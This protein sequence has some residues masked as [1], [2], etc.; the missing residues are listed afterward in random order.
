MKFRLPL[1][2]KRK[3]HPSR[4]IKSLKAKANEKRNMAEKFADWLTSYF[5]SITFLALNAIWFAA[6]I[7]INTGHTSI[8]P[9]D[10]FPFGLLT[11]IVSLEAIFLAIIV[12][13]SQ[14]REARIGELREEIDLQLN[15]ITEEESAKILELLILL[16]EKQG[17][18]VEYDAELRRL[19]TTSKQSIER[20]VEK[21]LNDKNI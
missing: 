5:G 18:E 8:E 16:L 11:M 10:E 3:T 15:T 4:D 12:L 21:E 20:E 19:M 1:S 17:I 9:F 2:E 13:I 6:W 7:V 14:N